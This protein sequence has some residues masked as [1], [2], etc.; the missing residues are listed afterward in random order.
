MDEF[1]DARD[2]PLSES[3]IVH[4]GSVTSNGGRDRT[5]SWMA[6]NTFRVNSLWKSFYGKTTLPM[7]DVNIVTA[8]GGCWIPTLPLGFLVTAAVIISLTD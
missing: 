8:D 3:L 1:H 7:P 2:L 5:Q 6:A 4:R